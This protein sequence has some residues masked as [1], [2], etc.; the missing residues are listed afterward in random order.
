MLSDSEARHDRVR[1]GQL[2]GTK[3]REGGRVEKTGEEVDE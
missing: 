1:Q 2:L 3:T